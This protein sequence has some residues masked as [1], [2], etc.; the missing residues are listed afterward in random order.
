M[1]SWADLP[2]LDALSA[3]LRCPFAVVD[4]RRRPRD[5]SFV[6]S[7]TVHTGATHSSADAVD[8]CEP[9]FFMRHDNFHYDLVLPRDSRWR[10]FVAPI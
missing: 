8:A 1:G 10:E 7:V 9:R 6:M 5:P 2:V 4:T 3:A